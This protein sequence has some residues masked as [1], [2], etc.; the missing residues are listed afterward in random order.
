MTDRIK[1]SAYILHHLLNV[2][3]VKDTETAIELAEVLFRRQYGVDS[4]QLQQPLSAKDEGDY[5]TISGT[6]DALD[7]SDQL[8]PIHIELM[9]ADASIVSF[10]FTLPQAIRA[11]LEKVKLNRDEMVKP[12]G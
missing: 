10:Q 12:K 8:G 2:E 4:L 1:G 9:K 3:M 11:K 6:S 5:W 7:P